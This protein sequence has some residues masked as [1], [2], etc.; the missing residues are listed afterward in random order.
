MPA[1]SPADL[2]LHPIRWRI[3]QAIAAAGRAT[4]RAVAQALPDVPTATLYRQLGKLAQ[5]GVLVVVDT[6][7][8]RGATEKTYALAEGAARLGPDALAG[9]SHEEHRRLFQVFIAGLIGSHERYLAREGLD[10]RRDGV[11]YHSHA[12]WLSDDELEMVVEGIREALAPALRY[13]P[14]PWRRPRVFAT[15]SMPA[16][17]SGPAGQAA[18]P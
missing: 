16:A 4:P 18:Q 14:A 17:G 12:L 10:P 2:L 15:V 13:G 6:R 11:G 9:A 5:G 3:V 8:A 7:Q 1:E